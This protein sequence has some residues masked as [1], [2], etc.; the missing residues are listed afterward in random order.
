MNQNKGKE[1]TEWTKIETGKRKI[2]TEERK[3]ESKRTKN[4]KRIEE[5]KKKRRRKIETLEKKLETE[6]KKNTK[7]KEEKKTEE[8]I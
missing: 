8:E 4:I 3:R 1:E 5:K 7:R 6:R 2:Y